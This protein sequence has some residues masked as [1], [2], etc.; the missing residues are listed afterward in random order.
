[1]KIDVEGAEV[2]ALR[3][4]ER[5]LSTADAIIIEIT[6]EGDNVF[7]HTRQDVIGP[8]ERWGFRHVGYDPLKRALQ[9]PTLRGNNIF[10]RGSDADL[11]QRL[12]AAPRFRVGGRLI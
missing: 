9:S 11:A 7:G 6:G 8:L 3:G 12:Q 2:E 4:G 1:M 5:T 10:V